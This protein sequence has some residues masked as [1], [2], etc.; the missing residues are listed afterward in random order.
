MRAGADAVVLIYHR[1]GEDAWP[2]TNVPLDAFRRQLDHLAKDGYQVVPLAVIAE[3]VAAGRTLPAKTVAIT[4]DDGYRST[5]TEAWPLLRRYGFPFTVFLYVEA[6]ERRYRNFLTW[7][8]IREMAA[9]GV[10]FQDHSYSHPRFGSRPAGA[11]DAAYRRWI[12]DD[13]FRSRAILQ[14]R[15]GK[16][17]RYLALPY[18]EYNRIVL[19]TVA[20]L[21]YEAVFSQDPGAVSGA[22]DRLRLPREPILGTDWSTLEHFAR[23]I[24]RIDLP[25]IDFWPSLD[26]LRD[27]APA[28][29]GGIVAH[30]G[31][32]RPDSFAVYVSELGWQ[33][34]QRQGNR[35]WIDN[36]RPLSRRQNRVM[37][38]ARLKDSNR[39]AVRFWLLIDD[40]RPAEA[41]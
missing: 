33:P 18:G 5:Y 21:G 23:V 36:P 37:I 34:A 27:L 32:Y 25:L 19:D 10:D 17:V 4:I 11:D 6:V 30:P 14:E 7:E 12:R 39:T 35:V 24:D 15:L 41:D 9:A 26:P 2:T 40:R 20:E 13:L 16:P 31:R 28:S 8:Q 1:F 3:S 38:S 22:S 29:F